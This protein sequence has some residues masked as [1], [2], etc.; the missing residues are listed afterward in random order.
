M[1][2]FIIIG[3]DDPYGKTPLQPDIVNSSG[4]K[5]WGMT[6]LTMGRYVQCF[7]LMNLFTDET[8]KTYLM[9]K[10]KAD[11]ILN[12]V[13]NVHVRTFIVCLGREVADSF[14]LY[15]VEPLKF[16]KRKKNTWLAYM[17]HTSGLNRWYNKA[18]N[19]R[20]ANNFM[21]HMGAIASGEIK[22]GLIQGILA[23]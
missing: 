15:G 21:R 7:E 19:V 23:E 8:S 5:L 22:N 18:D 13:D 14:R 12:T 9:A 4:N 10:T 6:G 20:A 2:R 17:P 3:I 1:A 11:S 16:F